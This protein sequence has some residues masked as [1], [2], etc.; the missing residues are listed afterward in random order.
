MRLLQLDRQIR[1]AARRLKPVYVG[2]AAGST[3]TAAL[4]LTSLTGG[5]ASAPAQN[6]IVI[7]ATA[8]G[9]MSPNVPAPGVTTA[10][11]TEVVD[12]A[13]PYYTSG[14]STFM[15][16]MA[17]AWKKMT[18]TPDTTV[19]TETSGTSARP[20]ATVVHVWRNLDLT[21][22]MDVTPTS[23][24]GTTDTGG[25]NSPAITPVTRHAWVLT[26]GVLIDD[27][28]VSSMTAPTGFGL[29]RAYGDSGANYT[30][31]AG[32]AAA[33]WQGGSLNPG[34]MGP[35]QDGAWCGA[36]LALRPSSA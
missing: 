28:S 34:R 3:R 22:P 33:N 26:A 23:T 14:G 32:I 17:V 9:A 5:I 31:A 35:A 12:V 24:S 19:A 25:P 16:G 4:S 7:V 13:S 30:I 15:V 29:L 6:D 18:G 2:G 1:A 21:T 27:F 8:F 11:Y 10:G 20:V 36:T